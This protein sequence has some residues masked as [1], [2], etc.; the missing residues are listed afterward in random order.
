MATDIIEPENPSRMVISF[1]LCSMVLL[2]T[3]HDRES[4][5]AAYLPPG[6]KPNAKIP[7][8]RFLA[9]RRKGVSDRQP[10]GP[11]DR[12]ATRRFAR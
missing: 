12:G 9:F 10:E 2:A 7:A 6:D 5:Q 4:V 3:V 8:P 1:R 11:A